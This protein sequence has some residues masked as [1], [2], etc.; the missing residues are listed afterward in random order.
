MHIVAATG[1]LYFKA[2][3]MAHS[4]SRMLWKYWKFRWDSIFI[5]IVRKN[6]LSMFHYNMLVIVLRTSTMMRSILFWIRIS[7]PSSSSFCTSALPSGLSWIDLTLELFSLLNLMIDNLD[8]FEDGSLNNPTGHDC[9]PFSCNF[10]GNIATCLY[11]QT[12][13]SSM[14]PPYRPTWLI[15][16]HVRL[17]P[18]GTPTSLE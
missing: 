15:C 12:H 1:L 7:S 4:I 6:A 3:S 17:H 16:R 9:P 10:E 14:S 11:E 2:R 8:M 13:I 5:F 18:S